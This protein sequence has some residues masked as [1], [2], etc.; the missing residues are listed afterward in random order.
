MKL[1]R[2]QGKKRRH[3]VRLTLKNPVRNSMPLTGKHKLMEIEGD[4]ENG[5]FEIDGEDMK[6]R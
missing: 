3:V 5:Y 2:Y 6:E 1:L 4:C